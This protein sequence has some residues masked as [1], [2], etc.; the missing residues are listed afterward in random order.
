[1]SGHPSLLWHQGCAEFKQ[2]KKNVQVRETL[3]C[4]D[5]GALDLTGPGCLRWLT[6]LELIQECLPCSEE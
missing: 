1:M 5:E 2:E 6:P 4:L 3:A